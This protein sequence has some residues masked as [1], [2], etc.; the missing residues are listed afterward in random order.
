[1]TLASGGRG[2]LVV[3]GRFLRA[4]PTGLQRVARQ[5]VGALRD[6][7]RRIEVLAPP[8]VDDTLADRMVWAPPGRLGD[9]VWEQVSLPVA[10]SGQTVLS[11]VNTAP[12]ACGR[13]VVMV[14]DLAT[15][16]GPQWFRPHMRVYGHLTMLAARRARA[17]V[18]PSQQ[19]ADEL[20][21]AGV[22]PDQ[23]HVVPNA[24]GPEFRAASGEAVADVRRRF[25]LDRPYVVHVGWADPRKNVAMAVTA[26][27]AV[28]A[29]HP[30]DLVLVGKTHAN[31]A[32]VPVPVGPGIR[33][34]GYVPD[35]LLPA[36]L[37]GA[38][39]LLYPTRYEGFGLPPLEA[40]AC[41]TPAVVSDLPAVHEAAGPN[42]VYVGPNDAPGWAEA[43][44]AVLSGAVTAGAAP[45]RRWSDMASDFVALIDRVES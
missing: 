15:L 20:L 25:G 34:L 16:V 29:D 17:V 28:V 24:V 12:L 9:H 13:S 30:H 4:T 36:L 32:P 40:L 21:R 23:L 26:H 38:A 35:L 44:R 2:A 1:M 19:V 45:T 8:G 31:F 6:A 42:A 22:D 10:A 43:L 3:N 39:A 27:Q 18:T 11:L 14:H 7:G 41:G 33:R 5:L 37:S